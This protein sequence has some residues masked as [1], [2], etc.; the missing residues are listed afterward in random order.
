M[1]I[2]PAAGEAKGDPSPSKD[3][4]NRT[5]QAHIVNSFLAPITPTRST[6]PLHTE[7][8]N[9]DSSLES[10]RCSPQGTVSE[11][12]ERAGKE[13]GLFSAIKEFTRTVP[14]LS[15]RNKAIERTPLLANKTMQRQSGS[16]NMGM[17]S[18]ATG[19]PLLVA[20]AEDSGVANSAHGA[21]KKLSHQVKGGE[22]LIRTAGPSWDEDGRNGESV[23]KHEKRQAAHDEIRGLMEFSL[24]QCLLAIFAY[25]A[26]AVLAFSVVFDHW[27]IIDSAYFAVVTFSTIGFGDLVPDTYEGRIFTCFFALSGVAFLGIALG[28]VGNNIIEA[29]HMAV[30]QAGEISKHHM[31]TLFAEG[32]KPERTSHPNGDESPGVRQSPPGRQEV[33]QPTERNPATHILRESALVLVVLLVFASVMSNDPGI[34]ANWDIGTGLYFAISKYILCLCGGCL[35]QRIFAYL[36]LLFVKTVCATTVGYGDFAPQTQM[37]RLFAIFFIPLAVGTMGHWLSVVASSIIANRQSSFHR[38]LQMQELS[39]SDLDIMDEDG[40]GNV[41]RA[42]FLEFML[43]AMNKVDKD[44]IDEMRGHFERLDTDN[45]GV[46][47]RDDLIASAKRKLQNPYRKLELS[48]YKQQLLQQAADARRTNRRGAIH[49]GI[50]N[51]FPHIDDDD[52][53]GSHTRTV[54]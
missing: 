37:G 44:F 38:R 20:T 21:W 4:T 35:P 40:D 5:T 24:W 27:T 14:G 8:R 46:L 26:I 3:S 9:E 15:R 42:E 45:T 12:G 31:I 51:M 39:Q 52:D 22:F 54:V 41:S 19:D 25:I 47:S 29:E 2:L 16:I 43:V 17:G 48:H 32:E 1:T 33:V 30:K 10:G 53:E 6:T 50:H 34:D 23:S 7:A 36:L 13:Q 28:V 11:E 18:N 49:W